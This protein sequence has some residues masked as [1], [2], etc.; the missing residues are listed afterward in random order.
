[1]AERVLVLGGGQLGLMMAESAARLGHVVDR[2]DPERDLILPGTSDMTVKLDADQC[3]AR[4]DVIT[5]ERE[6]FPDTGASRFLAHSSKCVT[7]TAL[8]VLPDRMLQKQLLDRL[9]VPTSPWQVLDEPGHLA[10]AR[11]ALGDVVIK[12][13]TGGYDGRGLWMVDRDDH[14]APVDELSGRAIIERKIPF[15]RELSVVGARQADGTK[16]FYP[17]VRNWHVDGILRLTL[18]P[19][20]AV[21]RSLQQEAEQALGRIMD[22]L[23][24]AGVMA[25][26]FFQHEGHLLVNEIAPRVHNS[27][28]WSQEGASISQFELHLRAMTSLPLAQPQS[29]GIT[30]MV[31]LIGEA[32]SDDWLQRPGVLHWYGKSV[33]PGRKVGHVNLVAPTWAM[34]KQQVAEWQDVLPDD[35]QAV[36]DHEAAFA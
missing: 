4:Y 7:R 24:Y 5:A 3:L 27:G 36:I 14:D 11:Q 19:G 2:Y 1:M 15:E 26:E 16:V 20:N 28:H 17:L 23:E 9:G 22:E 8:E 34:L 12:A 13:R 18:A 6:A 25:V 33:R 30:A 10:A 31:N 32:F 35:V 29:Q 21:T